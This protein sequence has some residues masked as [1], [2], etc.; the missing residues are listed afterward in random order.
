LTGLAL[1]KGKRLLQ[2]EIFFEP[3]STGFLRL[4]GRG[5]VAGAACGSR[6]G[7]G[8]RRLSPRLFLPGRSGAVSGR[9]R[10]CAPA[11][12]RPVPRRSRPG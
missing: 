10:G 11:A 8:A 2:L 5:R 3:S 1:E 4:A 12:L 7:F 6:G 9:P